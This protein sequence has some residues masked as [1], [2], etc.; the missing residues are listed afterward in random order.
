ML[1][2]NLA[3]DHGGWLYQ[4]GAKGPDVLG[5][6]AWFR[7]YLMGDMAQKSYF[8]GANCTFCKDSRVTVMQNSFLTQ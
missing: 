5:M 7:Y 2:D 1:I 4:N 8:F 6:T 3:S